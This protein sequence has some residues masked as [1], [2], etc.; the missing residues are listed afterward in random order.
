MK[1]STLAAIFVSLA[2]SVLCHAS[3][4]LFF[5][6]DK[7]D[8]M[9]DGGV[10]GDVAV[11]G[12]SFADMVSKDNMIARSEPEETA[13]A[14]PEPVQP[15]ETSTATEQPTKAEASKP[16]AQPATKPAQSLPTPTPVTKFAQPI[17][18]PKTS[19]ADIAPTKPANA[20]TA[21][22]SKQPAQIPV[23]PNSQKSRS[24]DAAQAQMPLVQSTVSKPTTSLS[25][26]TA[27]PTTKDAPADNTLTQPVVDAASNVENQIQK[28]TAPETSRDVAKPLD[29]KQITPAAPQQ[30]QASK[31]VPV[32]SASATNP[33][34]MASTSTPSPLAVASPPMPQGMERAAPA[35]RLAPDTVQSPST[36]LALLKP[37]S[38]TEA[39]PSSDVAPA[40]EQGVPA[41]RARPPQPH[42]GKTVASKPKRTAQKP[43]AKKTQKST[44]QR[45]PS[46]KGN[47]SKTQ[48][49]ARN[50]SGKSTVTASRGGGKGSKK[51]AA[52]NAKA[53]N[54]PGLVFRK[55]QRTRQKRV[56]GRGSVRIRF[57]VSSNG[58]LAGISVARS[59]GS[60]K[61]DQAALAHIRRAAPFPAPPQGARR[62]FTIPIE[63]RR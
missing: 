33:P 57:S 32:T 59:S 47:Q 53:S 7:V 55:I 63:I 52:G 35:A 3:I 13:Q 22:L 24:T 50:N 11:I 21:P 25:T 39:P 41:P 8:D 45:Q 15:Q 38:P 9:L 17:E 4:S 29:Q 43:A 28:P 61:I 49:S 18:V 6:D 26:A 5:S 54:Y 44:K 34:M 16:L 42:D 36:K 51:K 12:T 37:T 23:L 19:K 20:R 31:P 62:S 56:G 1:V 2:L 27:T 30:E 48:R 14:T 10:Q 60:N 58:R 46:A 40:A